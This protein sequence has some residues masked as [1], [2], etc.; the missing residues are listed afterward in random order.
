MQQAA[1][2]CRGEWDEWASPRLV[3]TKLAV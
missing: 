3:E 2:R 1:M